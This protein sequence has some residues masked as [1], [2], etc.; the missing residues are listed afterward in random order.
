MRS[1]RK[2]LTAGIL[3]TILVASFAVFL[4]WRAK[5]SSQ[6]NLNYSY[7]VP[8]RT[9]NMEHAATR[10]RENY[11]LRANTA[12]KYYETWAKANKDTILH[13]RNLNPNDKSEIER[14]LR[15]F[16]ETPEKAGIPRG[17][18]SD[19]MTSANDLNDRSKYIFTWQPSQSSAILEAGMITTKK[20]LEHQHDIPLSVSVSGAGG[21]SIVL[22]A[23]GRITERQYV[24]NPIKTHGSPAL[25][26]TQTE[27]AP[28]FF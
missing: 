18:F 19:V 23:S 8:I 12:R 24:R 6:D 4:S 21:S 13:I 14:V 3:V 10:R 27:I 22:W 25:I 2:R 28:A 17:E 15:Q 16:P 20:G 7:G 1:S 11:L 26:E 9:P 5:T